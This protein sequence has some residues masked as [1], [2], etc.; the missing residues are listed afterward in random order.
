[1]VFNDNK[2]KL[3]IILDNKI[4]IIKDQR[5]NMIN[6]LYEVGRHTYPK[7]LEI[8]DNSFGVILNSLKHELSKLNFK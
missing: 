3:K 7:I 1:K 5:D 8:V 6:K 2:A 4:K